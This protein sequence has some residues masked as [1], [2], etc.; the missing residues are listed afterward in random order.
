MDSSSKTLNA[1]MQRLSLDPKLLCCNTSEAAMPCKNVGYMACKGC[2]L[3]SYCSK[4]CQVA[5]WPIHRS[6]C[7]SIKTWKPA[8]IKEHRAPAF[9]ND[10]GSHGESYGAKKYLWGNVPAIDVIQLEKNEGNNFREPLNLLFAASGDM[11]N[12][13]LSVVNLPEYY[14]GRLDIVLND[15]EM[16]IVARNV[17]FLL[18]FLVE[19][20]P[21]I[22][23][24]HVLHIWYSTLIT[25]SCYNLLQSK[26]RPMVEDVCN[27]IGHRIGSSLL[28]KT[29]S[30]G[31][32]SV[33]LVLSRD[34]WFSLRSY[35]D[36]PRGLTKDAAQ[37][38]RQ[39]VMLA[40]ERVDYVDRSLCLKSP[41]ERLGMFKFR[42][43]GM[44]LPF[45]HT[46][47]VFTI[48][49]PT[50]FNSIDEWPMMDSSDP[51]SGWSLE[52]FLKLDI[53]PARHDIYGKLHHYLRQLFASFHYRLRSLPVV[54]EFLRV[55]AR[56][57]HKHTETKFDRIDVSNIT[58]GYYLGIH[59]TLEKIGPLLQP[60]VIN[61]HATLIALFLNAV[62][63]MAAY[64]ESG[65]IPV[66]AKHKEKLE[67]IMR[68]M[69]ELMLPDPA[70]MIKIMMAMSL[71]QDM[72]GHFG[73]YMSVHNCEDTA[74]RVGLQIKAV[75]T[76]IE[77]WPMR[78]DPEPTDQAK[79]YF[80]L[81]LSS[82]HT[83]QERYV[84]WSRR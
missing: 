34:E 5:H 29:W 53:G 30:F 33:R 21:I 78:I 70:N 28:A 64:M 14:T 61:R 45:G 20:D 13:I 72:D 9:M 63:E 3:V 54:F 67:K 4:N 15:K 8:W 35:F 60:T 73:L 83:G 57:L 49:N 24:E 82:S 79:E 65:I 75:H 66:Q 16:D 80:A 44:L 18:V 31:S 23:A 74:L 17:V 68:Y 42:S 25:E 47:A 39:G 6:D 46:R 38:V 62:P 12:T 58:D 11:R 55:D 56:S 50:V 76:I 2:L 40:P 1:M 81:L 27:K 32:T 37:R 36:V 51:T 77:P 84:E 43:D 10:S 71:V 59:D 52:S 26:L 69:P 19:D 22:A 48:P 41:S 7:R